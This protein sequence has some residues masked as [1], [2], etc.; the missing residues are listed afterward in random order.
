ML[1][2]KV[3]DAE[4]AESIEIP[5]EPKGFI[6]M[7][8]LKAQFSGA[9]GLKFKTEQ[10]IWRGY[11][12]FSI[13]KFE[14]FRFKK[15]NYSVRVVENNKTYKLYPPG[16]EWNLNAVYIVTYP[17]GDLFFYCLLYLF[18]C[19]KVKVAFRKRDIVA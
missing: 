17:K 15:I 6:L 9:C 1:F 16:D 2:V 19:N 12:F 4:N 18:Y 11:Y 5:V 3:A 14:L 13:F 8:T 7:S 10:F